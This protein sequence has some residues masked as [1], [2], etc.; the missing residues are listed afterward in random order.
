MSTPKKK[1]AFKVEGEPGPEKVAPSKDKGPEVYRVLTG[2]NYGDKRADAGDL[3]DDL[4][5]KSV[6]WLL[7][8]GHIQKEN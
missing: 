7:A 4:P 8:D 2:L 3:V 5:E 6:K 1:P